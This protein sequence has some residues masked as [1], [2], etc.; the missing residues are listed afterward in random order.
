MLHYAYKSKQ[1]KL[2]KLIITNHPK[3]YELPWY[4]CII[5]AIFYKNTHILKWLLSNKYY[6]ITCKAFDNAIRENNTQMIRWSLRHGIIY[7]PL[8]CELAIKCGR[9]RILKLISQ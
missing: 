2:I 3:K 1:S 6:P 9:Y 4:S 8:S 5:Y 7:G